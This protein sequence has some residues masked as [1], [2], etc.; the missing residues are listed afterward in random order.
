MRWPQRRKSSRPTLSCWA[1]GTRGAEASREHALRWG[2]S[3]RVLSL[4]RRH[5]CGSSWSRRACLGP[6]PRFQW[7]TNSVAPS[8]ISTWGG[9]TSKSLSN[10]MASSIEAVGV[11]TPGT[12]D[13]QRCLS[14]WGG[15]SFGWSL[16]TGP[17][18]SFAGFAPRAMDE[19]PARRALGRLGPASRAL[20]EK[21][22]AETPMRAPVRRPTARRRCRARAR[23]R[24]PGSGRCPSRCRP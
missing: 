2:C 12:Y 18:T 3:T 4:R 20:G 9:G 21:G 8:L 1:A 19:T 17:A 11:N 24:W 5:G 10:T 13:A 16:V 14:G 22:S 6:R 7:S 15:P 23:Q